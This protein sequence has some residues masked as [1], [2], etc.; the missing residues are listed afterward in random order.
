MMHTRSGMTIPQGNG[1]GAQCSP[2]RPTCNESGRGSRSAAGRP[3]RAGAALAAGRPGRAGA[4]LAAGRPRRAGAALAA[5]CSRAIRWACLSMPLLC[6]AASLATAAP[7]VTAAESTAPTAQSP[8]PTAKSPAPAAEPLA[9]PAFLAKVQL[10]NLAG[11]EPTEDGQGV[12]LYRLPKA[13]RDQ[14]VETNKHSG[15]TGADQMLYA[16]HSEIRFVL[17]DGEKVENVKIHLQT[18]KPAEVVFYWGDVLCGSTRIQPGGKARPLV[19]QGH[20]LLYSLMDQIPR[21]R[22]ATRVCRI[23][24]TGGELTL[25]GIEGD[26]RPPTPDEL[27]PVMVSYGTSI[28]QGAAASRAD[29]AWNALTARALGYDFVN[30]G[31]SGTAYCEPAVADYLAAQP[32]ELAVLEISVNMV[33]GYS[34]EEFRTRAAYL[35]D[36]LA[37]SH[38]DAPIVCISIFPWGV[39]DFWTNGEAYRKTREFRQALEEVCKASAH[40]NVHFVSG[41]ELLSVSGLSQDVLHPS[42]QGMIEIATKLAA[43]IREM[44]KK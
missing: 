26:V 14:M 17:N 43:R 18:T 11:A 23:V 24:L 16:R 4:A 13:V 2:G 31:C 32:W 27:A 12:K 21:G 10:H 35:I 15:A 42:D 1:R 9:L 36:T 30:L 8:A 22:F 7:P 25:T 19:P 37:K 40:R 29:L 39:G 38:P 41:P 44:Q 5:G 33:G 28:S 6:L 34:T 3:R 20:G